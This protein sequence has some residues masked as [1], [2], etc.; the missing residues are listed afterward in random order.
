MRKAEG[1]WDVVLLLRRSRK[2]NRYDTIRF[3]CQQCAEKYLKARL[4]EAG[5]RF[6][7]SHDLAALLA[8]VL[9]MEPAWALLR[10]ELAAITDAAVQFRYPGKWASSRDAKQAFVICQRLRSMV[11]LSLGI[12]S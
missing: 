3:H 5:T 8:L 9:P 1:D 12:K 6:P 7:Y 2:R 11:R 4:Q 10:P